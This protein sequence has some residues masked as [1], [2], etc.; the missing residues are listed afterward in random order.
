MSHMEARTALIGFEQ[1]MSTL[2]VDQ[3]IQFDDGVDFHHG[4]WISKEDNAKDKKDQ[5][6][7]PDK[8]DHRNGTCLR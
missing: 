6:P 7:K 8:I 2:G 5:R 4:A 3:D 1:A